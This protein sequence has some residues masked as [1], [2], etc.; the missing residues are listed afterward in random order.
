M[1]WLQKF[2]TGRYGGDQLSLALIVVSV[3]LTFIGN[4]IGFPI[5]SLLG[6]LPL[7]WCIFRMLSK[8]IQK[9]QMENY[10]FAMFISPAYTF[11]KKITFRI[12]DSKTH[13][14]YQCPQCKAK[15]RLPKGKGKIQI[16]CTKCKTEFIKKT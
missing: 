5:L 14:I 1:N 2:M 11:F 10:R 16:I 6:Y 12:K 9:R 15:L 3:L 8:N 7:G 13:K 4:A